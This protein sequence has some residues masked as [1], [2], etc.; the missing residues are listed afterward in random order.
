MKYFF[1]LGRNP[2]L[3]ITEIFSYLEK[4][5]NPVLNYFQNKNGFLV[6]VKKEILRG[7]IQ[8]LGGTIKFG[9]V[10]CFGNFQEIENFLNTQEIY[11]GTKNKFNYV[12]WNFSNQFDKI[13][14][15]LKKRFKSEKLKA[16]NKKITGSLKLQSGNFVKNL[17]S[18]LIDEEYFLFAD[19]EKNYFGKIEE[20]CDYSELELRDMEKPIRRESLAISP[21]LAKIMINLSEVKKSEK[22]VDPFCGIGVVLQEA[23]IQEIKVVGIDK[24]K[25]AI[26]G[27]RQNLKWGKFSKDKYEL[28]N[29]DSKQIKIQKVNVLVTEPDL[30]EILKKIPT[31]EKAKKIILNFENL[32]VSVLNN[33]KK[34]IFGRIVFS[35]PLIKTIKGRISLDIE[36]VLRKTNL[37]LVKGFPIQEFRNNQIVGRNIFVL[38]N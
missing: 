6:E 30:G 2:E 20:K 8:N 17:S 27:A 5:E 1:I 18:N 4:V 21:R 33:L 16:V 26:E 29:S 34:N 23:L 14:N 24:D 9:K 37:K 12:L 7:T 15:Y 13:L 28:L 10:L 3:S 19:R 35:S 22:L 32:I 38:E 31:K 36:K 11:L 25:K